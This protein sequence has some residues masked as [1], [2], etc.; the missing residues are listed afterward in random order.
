[1]SYDLLIKNA[2]IV[3][4]SGTGSYIGDVGVVGD[5]I[6]LVG[7]ADAGATRVIDVDGQV[8][9]PGFIDTHT[10]YDGQLFWD[11]W[12]SPTSWHGFTSVVIGHC[13]L[14][15]APLRTSDRF[16][17]AQAFSRVED[18]PLDLLQE[19]V[20]W[21]WESYADYLAVLKKRR[22]GINVAP[23]VGHSAIR[24]W[25]MGDDYQ[26]EAT[27]DEIQQMREQLRAALR[28]GANGF[29]SSHGPHVDMQNIPVASRFSTR[30]ELRAIASV[31]G[32][33]NV[34]VYQ[35][36]TKTLREGLL[37]DE[38]AF[39]EDL[40]RTTRRPATLNGLEHRKDNCA[41]WLEWL[42]GAAQRGARM[43][44]NVQVM[45]IESRFLFNVLNVVNQRSPKLVEFAR[46]PVEEQTARLAD[47]IYRGE[48]RRE[49]VELP[50]ESL[51][52]PS[53]DRCWVGRPALAKNAHLEGKPV[54]ELARAANRDV[55][56]YVMD[57]AAEEG[58]ATE[59]RFSPS[60][61]GSLELARAVAQ[62]P[63]T[64]LGVSD[65]GAH[66]GTQVTTHVST[67]FLGEWVRKQQLVSLEE[68][69]QKLTFVPAT[70]YGLARRGLIQEGYFADL[71][72]FDPDTIDAGP[73][74]TAHDLPGGRIRMTR[75]ATGISHVIVNGQVVLDHGAPTEDLPGRVLLNRLAKD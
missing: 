10:H 67:Y 40:S 34:G 12:L 24:R 38:R 69:V 7:I 14:T 42:N 47:P 54:A 57:L 59:F 9:A 31:M 45:G 61:D 65:G 33:E 53:W 26:R 52:R 70:T 30:D 11:P 28:A 43:R 17:M 1:M 36:S 23:Q 37:E 64:L 2:R 29:T 4:G 19:Y 39:L 21:Q 8:V 20:D 6:A 41:G 51:L 68:A 49:L 32:E 18:I 56:D 16:Y 72:V 15:L 46:L 3:D 27:P 62:S 63:Y 48:I 50:K 35:M 44:S 22:Y 66:L 60:E 71:V 75:Q 58:F 74:V 25:V 73:A 5:T 55:V 13:G